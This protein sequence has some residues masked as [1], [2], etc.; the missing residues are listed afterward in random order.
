MNNKD[1]FITEGQKYFDYRG[2]KGGRLFSTTFS[3]SRIIIVWNYFGCTNSIN[4][5]TIDLNDWANNPS[6]YNKWLLEHLEPL[7]LKYNI[8]LED[9]T[10][11]LGKSI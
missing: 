4:G 6:K 7:R 1:K 5:K 9:I 11:Y 10:V 8:K 3:N 2:W